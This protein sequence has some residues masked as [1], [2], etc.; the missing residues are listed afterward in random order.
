MVI[1]IV[2]YALTIRHVHKTFKKWKSKDKKIL[3]TLG[4]FP[5]AFVLMWIPSIMNRL[6]QAADPAHPSFG[7]T[8]KTKSTTINIDK[9]AQGA[10]I[11]SQ[12]IWNFILYFVARNRK[13]LTRLFYRVL[14]F[15]TGK[16]YEQSGG[17]SSSEVTS[18]ERSTM[19]ESSD[20]E[21]KKSVESTDSEVGLV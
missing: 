13:T 4:L 16:T 12:G 8:V 9:I 2:L 10:T 7:F 1:C 20:V 18:T 21:L 14:G 3:W 5:V 6:Q 19:K 15:A 17:A 11:P